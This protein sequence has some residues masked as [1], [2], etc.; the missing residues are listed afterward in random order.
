MD[1]VSKKDLQ[2]ACKIA[3]WMSHKNSNSATM[4]SKT[5]L[6]LFQRIGKESY[7]K[8]IQS[9][10][11][12]INSSTS[13]THAPGPNFLQ[14]GV[15]AKSN[16]AIKK[17]YEMLKREYINDLFYEHL[18]KNIKPEAYLLTVL[19][20][21][22]KIKARVLGV[23]PDKDPDADEIE[24]LVKRKNN[25][26]DNEPLHDEDDK[27]DEDDEDELD[28]EDEDELDEEDEDELDE[29]DE[30]D[31]DNDNE[32]ER[33]NG[34]DID[35]VSDKEH[36]NAPT[37]HFTRTPFQ[38]D[39]P[40]APTSQF[41]GF[42]GFGGSDGFGSSQFG[43]TPF[44]D[45]PQSNSNS[46]FGGF[47]FQYPQNSPTPFQYNP[48]NGFVSNFGGFDFQNRTSAPVTNS[49][50]GVQNEHWIDRA[51]RS[52]FS[53]CNRSNDNNNQTNPVRRSSRLQN[54]RDRPTSY[55][56][57]PRRTQPSDD[58]EEYIPR[59][60]QCAVDSPYNSYENDSFCVPD[61]EE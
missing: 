31:D 13:E 57:A 23:M 50:F 49:G 44:Q 42:G 22:D 5:A 6:S 19:T 54:K 58:E 9:C 30:L 20:D 55:Q 33:N 1:K 16:A 46:H 38:D 12:K 37:A 28:E 56:E 24:R 40:S 43:R 34:V 14:H 4:I 51:V 59:K 27:D 26:S 48:P 3:R 53:S 35:I 41:G 60:R 61:D 29:E 45:N 47:G 36:P 11:R 17:Y 10:I 2:A 8:L 39:H 15:H 21:D 7:A 52:T 18:E 32:E 25:S